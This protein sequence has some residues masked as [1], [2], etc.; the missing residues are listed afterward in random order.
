MRDARMAIFCEVPMREYTANDDSQHGLAMAGRA[1]ISDPGHEFPSV[2]WNNRDIP[3]LEYAKLLFQNKRT[4][5]DSGCR[6]LTVITHFGDDFPA[7][8]LPAGSAHPGNSISPG[9]FHGS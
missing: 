7:G 4:L 5:V 8:H 3:L 9:S 6:R 1:S 2:S